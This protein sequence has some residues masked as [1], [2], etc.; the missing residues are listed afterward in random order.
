MDPE[1]RNLFSRI[2]C[3]PELKVGMMNLEVEFKNRIVGL[4]QPNS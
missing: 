1:S 4:T 2:I 3:Q